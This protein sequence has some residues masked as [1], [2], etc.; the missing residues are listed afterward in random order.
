MAYILSMPYGS[1]RVIAIPAYVSR[2]ESMEENLDARSI[3]NKALS[4]VKKNID[5][6]SSKTPPVIT[7]G[8]PY[9]YL[10]FR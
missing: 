8:S 6:I 9:R 1:L 2:F 5:D 4:L 10:Y 3:S 7:T